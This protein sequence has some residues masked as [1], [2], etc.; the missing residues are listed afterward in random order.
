MYLM[1]KV[2][3]VLLSIPLAVIGIRKENKVL[4]ALSV[5]ILIY[6][7]GVA[8]TRSLTF[9]R[10]GMEGIIENVEDDNYQ[11]ES[12][13][14]SIYQYHCMKCHGE[15][16]NKMRYDSPDITKSQLSKDE[17]WQIIN[18]GKGMMPAFGNKLDK[19]EVAALDAYLQTL[20]KN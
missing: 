6:V 15:E 11:L 2:V 1:V 18:N 14:K 17:R 4:L 5:I 8:E 3:L 10:P 12:H 16:G 9:S 7:Y 13:G 20:I 19:N